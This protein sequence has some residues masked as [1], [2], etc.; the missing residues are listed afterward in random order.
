MGWP[1]PR[2]GPGEEQ[3]S[4]PARLSGVGRRRPT[5]GSGGLSRLTE[6]WVAPPVAILSR[7]VGRL[8]LPAA[9]GLGAG[10]GQAAY[11]LAGR[12]RRVVLA[13]LDLALG[14]SVGPRRR[15]ALARANFR[16]L[17][18]TAAECCRLFFGRPGALLDRVRV[19]GLE[20]LKAALAEGRGVF[21][22]TA[23]FGNW[24]L[25]AAA[26]ALAGLPLSVVVRPLDNPHLEGLLA[27]GRER[28]GLRLIPKRRAVVSV[29]AALARGEC[30]GILL[31]QNAGRDGVFVPFFGHLASTSRSLAVLALKTQAPVVPV[32][33]R[34]LPGG[35]HLVT[36]DP[37]LPLVVTGDLERDV[38]VN[39]ACFTETIERHVRA[40]PEQW[41]WVHRRWKTRP[42]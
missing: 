21:C 41:F 16:H 6:R 28:S 33:V 31:D 38:V 26:H 3:R 8:P 23:H 39:T 9:R 18:I 2:G 29:G 10:L 19:E 13:N 5:S 15:R 36:L 37:A 17:G 4:P 14:S 40:Q 20:H 12:R 1:D 32:F 42:A 35:E 22:L 30:V 34:R 24:E 11:W 27:R 25:L 7:L